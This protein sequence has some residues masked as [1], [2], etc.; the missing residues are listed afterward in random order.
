[1]H[2]VDKNRRGERSRN[3]TIIRLNF[4]DYAYITH[5]TNNYFCFSYS[6]QRFKGSLSRKMV[7]LDQKQS[8]LD[9]LLWMF[10]SPFI[11]SSPRIAKGYACLHQY[12]CSALKK[13]TL[14]GRL[15]INNVWN[16]LLFWVAAL[17]SQQNNYYLQILRLNNCFS[18]AELFSGRCASRF[19]V[20]AERWSKNCRQ[21]NLQVTQF[22]M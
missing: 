12:H 19:S 2:S 16:A 11:S 8:T 18:S 15:R 1:M 17:I 22:C 6:V 13:K 10:I 5:Y 7:L 3:A 9:F 21:R 4:N 14:F 20:A